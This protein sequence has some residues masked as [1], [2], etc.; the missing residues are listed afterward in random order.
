M[1]KGVVIDNKEMIGRRTSMM[2]AFCGLLLIL[3]KTLYPFDFCFRETYSNIGYHFLLLGWGK[4][5]IMDFQGNVLL[6]IPLGFGLAGY[7]IQT[8]RLARMTS[9]ALAILVSFGLSYTVEVLQV[10]L[11]T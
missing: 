7:L 5:G 2:I 4:S 6:Y 1:G 8:V 11:P 3:Y 10:F 9:L